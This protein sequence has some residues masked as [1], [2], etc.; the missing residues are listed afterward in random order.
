MQRKMFE[1]L[2]KEEESDKTLND[3]N[4]IKISVI[5][6]SKKRKCK[7]LARLKIIRL[8]TVELI[9]TQHASRK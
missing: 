8:G 4:N 1:G 6:E 9:D 5:I 2:V 7:I 3:D